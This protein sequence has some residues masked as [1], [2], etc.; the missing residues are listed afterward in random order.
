MMHSTLSL[1]AGT[2]KKTLQLLPQYRFLLNTNIENDK[3]NIGCDFL[4]YYNT[5]KSTTMRRIEN[6]R[7][8]VFMTLHHHFIILYNSGYSP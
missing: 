8:Y 4:Y 5:E 3:A 1:M 6:L 7:T 2:I